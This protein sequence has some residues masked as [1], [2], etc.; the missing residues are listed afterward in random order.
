VAAATPRTRLLDLASRASRQALSAERSTAVKQRLYP[1][2]AP[3]LG[4][5]LNALGKLY[6]TDKA[7][8]HGY[9]PH[10]QRHL[11]WPRQAAI[12]ILE[13]GVGGS[14]GPLTGGASLR[15]WASYYPRARVVGID[16]NEKVVDFPRV[17]IRRGDQSDPAFLHD[18]AKDLGGS[19]DLV[20]DDGSHVSAHVR[21]SFEV[22]FPYVS[23]GG[24]YV[25]EDLQ[26]SYWDD[27][28]GAPPGSGA[29]T[30]AE[31]AKSLLDGLN[32]ESYRVDG[33]QPTYTD[34]HVAAI[35]AYPNIVFLEKAAG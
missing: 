19:I 25:I 11:H 22:L 3:L 8:Q 14:G 23:P 26:T 9:T 17:E 34:R 12:S 28:G 35:H 16:I 6:G 27:Y 24:L 29:P 10:Y 32:H 13:I 33:Y 1:V 18:V 31:L 20:V 21:A 4:R 7:W 15:M 2:I 5:D 30:T